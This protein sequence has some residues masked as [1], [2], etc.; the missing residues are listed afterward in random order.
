[1]LNPIVC[2]LGFTCSLNDDRGNYTLD[3]DDME[4]GEHALEPVTIANSH[5][6]A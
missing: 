4:E 2:A 1:M 5:G 3:C 6:E